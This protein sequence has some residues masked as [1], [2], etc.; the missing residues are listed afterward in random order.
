MSSAELETSGAHENKKNSMSS[1]RAFFLTTFTSGLSPQKSRH[2]SLPVQDSEVEEKS[3]LQTET[4]H[5]RELC[6]R[7]LSKKNKAIA[8]TLEMKNE[9]VWLKT[10]CKVNKM[11]KN[12]LMDLKF[13]S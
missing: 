5:R 3:Q 8:D 10:I 1:S 9:D 11:A 2:S 7:K 4:S 6:M 12:M 13:D